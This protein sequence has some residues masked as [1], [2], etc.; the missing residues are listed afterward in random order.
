MTRFWNYEFLID[1]HTMN[2]TMIADSK[3]ASNDSE[4]QG[5]CKE[6]DYSCNLI[7]V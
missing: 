1:I 2:R 7:I 3:D 4:C 5:M 6:I